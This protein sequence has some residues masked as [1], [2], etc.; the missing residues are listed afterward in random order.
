MGDCLC[1]QCAALCCRYFALPIDNPT[2]R[3]DFDN[4]RWYLLHENVTV[5]VEKAQWYIG[6]ANRCKA[7]QTDNR[8]GIYLTRPQV[9]RK[10]S[11]DNCDYHGGEYNFRWLFTS[12]EQLDQFAKKTLAE[13]REKNRRRKARA[14]ARGKKLK[15]RAATKPPRRN[16]KQLSVAL[17]KKLGGRAAGANENGRAVSL[18][19]LKR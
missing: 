15:R 6:V 4:V 14:A 19:V 5:F 2:T 8:C 18:P 16:L 1:D 11:T 17:E 12:A 7:L 13:E 10:Y 3:K 9:C